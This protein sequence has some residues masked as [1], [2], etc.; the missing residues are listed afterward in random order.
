LDEREHVLDCCREN[1][2]E[3]QEIN[4]KYSP[5]T[6]E[7][8]VFG[9][10]D[11]EVFQ[12][13]NF[14]SLS[15]A[16]DN[17]YLERETEISFQNIASTA[18]AKVKKELG[19]RKQLRKNLLKDRAGHGDAES[20]KRF[21]DLLLANLAT[22][23]RK[24]KLV[25]VIDYFDEKTP[26]IFIEIDENRSISET[27][28]KYFKKYTKARNA[29]EQIS[30]R[31]GAVELEIA[32]LEDQNAKI[33][34]AIQE[35]DESFLNSFAG[36]R[37]K[38]TLSNQKKPENFSGAR[39]FTSSD[40]VEILVGRRA[41]DNDFLTFRVAKSLDFW[42]HA[43]DYPGSHVVVRNPNRAEISQTALL[44][45]AQIAAFYSQAKSQAKVAVHYTQKK[46]VNKPK[47][48]APG[49]V[50]LASF[51]TILVEPKIEVLESRP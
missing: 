29:R 1:T 3:G 24:G 44:E 35:R 14:E 7:S 51:K 11:Q 41:K 36:E 15:E 34:T 39:R 10:T 12:T 27:A 50:S 49:M 6:R 26:E 45:A 48:A 19:K 16:L 43:A 23:K 2:G 28:E 13:G 37:E 42:F 47:G 4:G 5:P 17:Y 9:T 20:W 22:A 33:E 18:R 25:S 40:G 46:F 31:L 32:K 8:A 30:K 38:A 21:G